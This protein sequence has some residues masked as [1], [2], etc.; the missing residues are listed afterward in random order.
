MHRRG[1][2]GSIKPLDTIVIRDGESVGSGEEY[3]WIKPKHDLS[4]RS[5]IMRV[6][7]LDTGDDVSNV[8]MCRAGV[9]SNDRDR[10]VASLLRPSSLGNGR[11]SKYLR[12]FQHYDSVPFRKVAE[13]AK[14]FLHDQ[15]QLFA[16]TIG[17]RLPEVPTNATDEELWSIATQVRSNWESY[18]GRFAICG[19][20]SAMMQMARM[21]EI[22]DS[23]LTFVADTIS[24]HGC[25]LCDHQAVLD[26]GRLSLAEEFYMPDEEEPFG[27]IVCERPADSPSD[28]GKI[29]T[30]RLPTLIIYLEEH[31]LVRES[32]VK[33][34]AQAN[35]VA[36]LRGYAAV[37]AEPYA[38]GRHA[39]FIAFKPQK[40]VVA[41][42]GARRHLS[43]PSIL[44]YRTVGK[45][46]MM[47]LA[48][49]RGMDRISGITTIPFPRP[50]REFLFYATDN[51]KDGH[52]VALLTFLRMLVFNMRLPE[53]WFT[54]L[55]SKF[56]N[57]VSEYRALQA[58]CQL[59]P[60]FV[61]SEDYAMYHT[62]ASCFYLDESI[63]DKPNEDYIVPVFMS[64]LCSL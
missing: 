45:W 11:T 43:V 4:V 9:M 36:T 55:N 53:P 6:Y 54:S 49:A 52:A 7:T 57:H 38:L 20:L 31:A 64:E 42:L 19:F 56:G 46:V 15:G 14:R 12:I 34:L 59:L 51:W 50:M 58:V 44:L 5:D 61:N 60:Q 23:F 29:D 47:A 35:R 16:D 28:Q 13:V 37:L 63:E 30:C 39:R 2:D 1:K 22:P 24:N 27:A 17:Y 62:R 32:R 40:V 18:R 3:L 33:L 21:D 8:A 41:S 10:G 48:H 25:T 26:S